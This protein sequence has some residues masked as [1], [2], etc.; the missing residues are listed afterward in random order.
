MRLIHS[1]RKIKE[2]DTIF[3]LRFTF[4]MWAAAVVKANALGFETVMYTD[5]PTLEKMKEF[6][7]DKVYSHVDT[8][9]LE[10]ELTDD[11]EFK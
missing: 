3:E 8:E 5:K 11:I 9:V 10:G 4:L 1:R 7:L 6:G 2:K